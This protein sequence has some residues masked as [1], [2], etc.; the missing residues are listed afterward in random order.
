MIHNFMLIYT[1]MLSP[2]R[3]IYILYPRLNTAYTVPILC[4][5]PY[6]DDTCPHVWVNPSTTHLNEVKG[7]CIQ[8][9]LS[10]FSNYPQSLRF[11]AA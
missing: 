11:T 7:Q 10:I 6:T 3:S 2:Y 4:H 9:V 8:I 1:T 5:P